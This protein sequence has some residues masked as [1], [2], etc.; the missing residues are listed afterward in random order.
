MKE[1]KSVH[2]LFKF[3]TFIER[4]DYLKLNSDVGVSTFGF[5]RYLNQRFYNSSEWKR[6]RD[7]VVLRDGG[8]DLGFRDNLIMDRFTI[9]HI[10]PITIED[11]EDRLD[12]VLDPVYL[13]TTSTKTHLAIHYGDKELLPKPLV[14]RFYGD[15]KMW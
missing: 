10:N 1:I 11:L 8:C 6:I 5:D 9:H 7:I 2:E 3:N 4:F 15:T 13:I 14:E 12:I